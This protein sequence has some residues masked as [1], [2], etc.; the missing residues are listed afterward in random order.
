MRV[1]LLVL[2]AVSPVFSAAAEE[3]SIGN[4]AGLG[5]PGFSGDYALAVGAHLDN[6]SGMVRG[7]DGAMWVCEY[8]GQRIRR[9]RAD[10]VIFTVGGDGKKRFAGDGGRVSEASFSM[11]EDVRFD[12]KGDLFIADMGNSVVR[13]V[14]MQ[15]GIIRTIAGTGLR[16]YEG[17]GGPATL[18]Y[19]RQP[20]CVRFGPDGDLYI[21]DT[22]NHAIRR[23]EMKTGI[24]R[25]V[26]GTGRPGVTPDGAP[27]EGTPLHGP[28]GMDFDRAGNLWVVTQEGNQVFKI[29][30]QAG[31]IFLMAGTGARGFSGNGGAARDATFKGPKGIAL[32]AEGNAWIADTE[33]NA[34]RRLDAK[35]GKVELM[36]GTGER[37]DGPEGDPLLCRLS[38][39]Q[40][41]F[42]DSDGSVYM[43]DSEAHRVRVLR[44][45]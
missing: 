37:G 40:C 45:K 26:A 7:P 11:P 33:N 2:L 8:G 19:L 12:G 17:D 32:D 18:A 38:R 20:H 39:V 3:W 36:A 27:L 4:V 16:G 29:D 43:G 22:G 44:K 23:L 42:V 34:V 25:A 24:L 13:K 31:R 9:I 14:N 41:V 1:L 30:L 6:P 28:R 35:T 15:S 5:L 10:G 21:A